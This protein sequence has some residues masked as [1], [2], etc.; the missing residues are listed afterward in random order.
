MP[1]HA[2]ST[3]EPIG[4]IDAGSLHLRFHPDPALR[5]KAR[6]VGEVTDNVRE[7][8]HRM[9]EIMRQEEGIGL[10]APQVGLPWRMFVCMIPADP[11]AG[12]LPEHIK[13]HT[14]GQPMVCI[15]PQL[16]PVGGLESIE[17]GC[18]SL[19]DIR[20]QVNRQHAVVMEAT[21]LDGERFEIQAVGL[22][23]RCIQHEV[24]HL[25]GVMIID[26]FGQLDRLRTRS[27]LRKL[28]RKGR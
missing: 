27:A 5:V 14:D 15:D 13:E 20:G 8:A 12:P 7:A 2:Q 4:S 19:P 17:E 10:A 18:L 11:K 9:L 26:K 28:E 24:D 6:P 22:L 16:S 1:Q 23:A 25:D 21:N 3:T